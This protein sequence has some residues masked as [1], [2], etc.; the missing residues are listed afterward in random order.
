MPS[1][2]NLRKQ[3]KLVLRWHHDRYYPVAA[4]I[5][6]LLPRFQHLS[7]SEVLTH[8]F[9][10]ADAKELVARQQGFEAGRRSNRASRP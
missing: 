1:L 2:E 5:R 9:K 8:P 3:A 4:Q 7:D 10:L 6:E